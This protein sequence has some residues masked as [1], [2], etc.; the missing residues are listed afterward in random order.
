[1]PSEA[2]KIPVPEADTLG[3][4]VPPRP[5][6]PAVAA[7]AIAALVIGLFIGLLFLL[8][9]S[10]AKRLVSGLFAEQPLEDV[11]FY[12]A[13]RDAGRL[14][15]ERLKLATA[16]AAKTSIELGTEA[17]ALLLAGRIFELP[18]KPL[19]VGVSVR[20]MPPEHLELRVSIPLKEPAEKYLNLRLALWFENTEK[21]LSATWKDY[22]A[23]S[24]QISEA[25][26]L[27]HRAPLAEVSAPRPAASVF[28]SWLVP[29]P[30]KVTISETTITLDYAP[31]PEHALSTPEP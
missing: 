2:P 24:L 13:G 11:T 7:A 21:G 26:L 17:M 15:L 30:R 8:A 19:R 23:G 25:L 4:P 18:A 27:E 5:R 9:R 12:E 31:A 29:V 20:L 16:A 6:M 1:M 3:P 28:D 14:E 22:Q 10:E